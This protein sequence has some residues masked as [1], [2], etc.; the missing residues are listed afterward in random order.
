[1]F[2]KGRGGGKRL[3]E[4]ITV[5]KYLGGLPEFR[6]PNEKRKIKGMRLPR[7]LKEQTEPQQTSTSLPNKG[8]ALHKKKSL[9]FAATVS[10]IYDLNA[11]CIHGDK[12][13]QDSYIFNAKKQQNTHV[14]S[15][16]SLNTFNSIT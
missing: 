9:L 10:T 7:H 2:W 8:R 1:M 12:A 4:L 3:L 16:L 5:R 13:I 6:K 11:Y 14:L 15:L